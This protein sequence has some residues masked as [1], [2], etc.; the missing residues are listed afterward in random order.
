MLG[1]WETGVLD[2]MQ[3]EKCG[4]SIVAVE[5]ATDLKILA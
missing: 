4:V 5:P 1:Y 3:A 2:I